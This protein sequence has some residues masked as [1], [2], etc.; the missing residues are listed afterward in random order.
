MRIGGKKRGQKG[1]KRNKKGRIPFRFGKEKAG[2]RMRRAMGSI[3]N[4]N[5]PGD[6]FFG[7]SAKVKTHVKERAIRHTEERVPHD[8]TP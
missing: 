2:S 1:I 7:G 4:K 8:E 3:L 5:L 6:P